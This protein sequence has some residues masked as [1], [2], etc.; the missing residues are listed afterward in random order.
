MKI[1]FVG[2]GKMGLNMVTR[3]T[4]GGHQVVAFDRASSAVAS[5]VGAG[6]S[7]AT[8]IGQ[9]IEQL[10]SP[11]I[12]WVMVPSGDATRQ[13]I[14]ELSGLLSAGDIIIDGGNSNFHDTK[15][16]SAI[17]SGKG[18]HLL[19]SGTSGGVWG[20]KVGYCLM[21]GGDKNAFAT[22]EPIFRTLAPPNGYMHC[23]PSGAG[24]YVK[25]IHNGIEYGMMQAYAEGFEILKAS[26]YTIDLAAVSNLWNQGS[27]VRS[28]LLELAARAFA[29][30]PHLDKL[31]GYVADSGEG[32]WTVIEAIDR[33]V[34]AVSLTYALM[35]RFRSRQEDSFSAK[36]LAALRNQFGGH[37]IKEVK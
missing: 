6:A 5:A 21:I 32:R 17:L 11:K 30:D 29:E 8:S 31:K 16:Q 26:E 36:V 20:L 25:M 27:V 12:V 24:H 4:Q 9:L 23:G 13:V 34:P 10:P 3:L 1:G 7:G 35:N 33:D 2:L 15:A 14:H 22:V 19:D 37:A 28:W 18:I